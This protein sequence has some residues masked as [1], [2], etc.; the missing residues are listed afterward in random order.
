MPWLPDSPGHQQRWYYR[1]NGFLSSTGHKGGVQLLVQCSEILEQCITICFHNYMQHDSGWIIP[2]EY[3]AL[4]SN[5]MQQQ[6]L[7]FTCRVYVITPCIRWEG[8]LGPPLSYSKLAWWRHQMETFSA[9]LALCAWNSPVTD[10]FPS[11]GPVTRSFDVFFDL[12][13]NKRLSKQSWGWW[14]GTP[15]RS[16]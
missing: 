12:C 9:L 16:V 3:I 2:F 6:S 5:I 13:L 4:P 8:M 1:I 7:I 11:Q 14:V 10:E 15:S